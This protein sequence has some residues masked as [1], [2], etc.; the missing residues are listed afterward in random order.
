MC[1]A[2]YRV[3]QGVRAESVN[4]ISFDFTDRSGNA[5]ATVGSLLRI[6]LGDV[7]LAGLDWYPT[8]N[9]VCMEISS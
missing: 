1:A 3:N 7:P 9:E 6:C 4:F 5:I 2:T 8:H